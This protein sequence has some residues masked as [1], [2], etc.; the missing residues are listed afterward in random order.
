MSILSGFIKTRKYRK[1][2]EGY[3]WQSEDTSAQTVFFDDGKNLVDKL[4]GLSF[5]PINEEDYKQ[6]TTKDSSVL[7]VIYG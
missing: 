2:S 7:Y 6:L 5:L 3:K 1:T 4:G